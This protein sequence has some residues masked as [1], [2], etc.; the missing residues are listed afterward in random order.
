MFFQKK[1]N[2]H[3]VEGFTKTREK[4]SNEDSYLWG[5]SDDAHAAQQSNK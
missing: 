4:W 1:Y 5:K 3:H 2:L